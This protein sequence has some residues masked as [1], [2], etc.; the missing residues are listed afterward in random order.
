[1]A[2]FWTQIGTLTIPIAVVL[3][4]ETES[5]FWSFVARILFIFGLVSIVSGWGFTLRDERKAKEK[6]DRESAQ[7]EKD[8]ARQQQEHDEIMAL[9]A[10]TGLGR[11]MS[12]PRIL[13]FIERVKELGRSES[14]R[15]D[16]L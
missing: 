4:L 8:E 13:R 14:E 3:L 6:E 1:M 7:R 5:E 16:N 2:T 9:L 11:K 10:G 12:S 15:D